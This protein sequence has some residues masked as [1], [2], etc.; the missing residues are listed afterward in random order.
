MSWGGP[1]NDPRPVA[2]IGDADGLKVGSGDTL[3]PAEPGLEVI[4][5]SP[6]SR[7]PSSISEALVRWQGSIT[8]LLA[9]RLKRGGSRC[10]LDSG[11]MNLV[12]FTGCESLLRGSRLSAV[13][14]NLAALLADSAGSPETYALSTRVD[15]LQFF[16]SHNWSVP[17]YKKFACLA[18]HFNFPAAVAT[19]ALT[20][21]LLAMLT[22][23]GVL[24]QEELSGGPYPRGICC[25]IIVAPVF[26]AVLC[27]AQELGPHIGCLGPRV[28]LDK[29]CINQADKDVQRLGID[30]LAAFLAKSS[31]MVVIY[32]DVYLTKLWT[33]YE[34]ASFLS[35]HPLDHML[36][37][38]T[39]VPTIFIVGL[40]AMY[41]ALL[42]DTL[43]GV[44]LKIYFTHWVYLAASFYGLL[45][46]LRGWSRDKAAMR[47]R[48]R[49]F[50]L[51]R[52]MCYC[53][54]DRPVIYG[55]IAI[56]MRSIGVAQ[57]EATDVQAQEAFN[58]LVR[59]SLPSALT[60]SMGNIGLPYK[61]VV[62]MFA[63]A[64]WPT[65]LDSLAGF[66]AGM[67][68]QET[69][70]D[71]VVSV[72]WTAAVLPLTV[73]SLARWSDCCLHLA[74]CSEQAWLASGLV[75][76]GAVVY[77][78]SLLLNPFRVWAAR[79]EA[80]L[81]A[82]ATYAVAL[83][84][85]ALVV[86]QWSSCVARHPSLTK[87]ETVWGTKGPLLIPTRWHSRRLTGSAPLE[88]SPPL[89]D[90]PVEYPDNCDEEK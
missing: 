41:V 73:A 61:H 11:T 25:R 79:S 19:T 9:E 20:M 33:V 42:L 3:Q 86:F 44:F 29:T 63:C 58:M 14:R 4:E 59:I 67:T 54:E 50:S 21:L 45:L 8:R 28:F 88:R 7:N 38:P 81:I 36:V 49:T 22:Y 48:L 37:I 75:L 32:T 84:S 27:F 46:V 56:L 43:S 78:H 12:S 15:R 26:F 47:Q 53:E 23:V 60:A 80:G 18:L 40:I 89:G 65:Y 62:A 17:R 85:V 1:T 2:S 13:M 74:A 64:Y 90:T 55:N 10:S 31:N 87:G 35:L 76:V 34:L 68:V 72:L 70:A 82:M 6:P 30:K 52:C 24:P 71:L 51:D 16:I 66:P 77:A 83:A 69:L 57:P 39:F 5:D